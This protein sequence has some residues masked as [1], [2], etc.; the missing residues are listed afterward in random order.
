MPSDRSIAG[1]ERML[2]EAGATNISKMFKDQHVVAIWFGIT[3]GSN[4]VTFR[5][6][7]RIDVVEKVLREQVKRPHKGTLDKIKKQAERTA[8]KIVHDWCKAQLAF[9][10]L[11]QAEAIEVFFAFLY[12]PI[13]EQ[14]LFQSMK[15]ANFKMLPKG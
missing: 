3:I 4:T 14:T 8:W 10:R 2:A 11:E 7:A 15:E 9:I 13:K 6:P 1:I 12:D 5:L